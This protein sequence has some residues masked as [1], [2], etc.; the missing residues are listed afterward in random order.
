MKAFGKNKDAATDVAVE[1]IS[2]DVTPLT[3]NTD[4]RAYGKLGWVV[5][6]LG[7]G[8]FLLWAT[9][10]PLDKGVPL[11]GTVAKE[12]NR[13]AVQYLN[14]GIV[15]NIL[16]HDGDVVKAGQVLVEM[17]DVQAKSQVD[18]AH[19]MY[20]ASRAA[21]A[22]L[23]AER[24]GKPMAFPSTLLAYKN[25]PH[26]ME[27][28]ALQKELMASRQSAL[29]NELAAMDENIAGL[30][31][32]TRG[33]EES[34]LSKVEQ[35]NSLKEELSGMRDLAK[36]G[37]VARN[38]LLEVERTY[39]Q[40]SGSISEDVGN[41]GRGQRQVMELKLRRIQ[42]EQE[43]QKDVRTQ[44]SDVQKDADQMAGRMAALDYD[45]ANASVKSPVDGVVVGSTV[46]TRGGV[47]GA[48]A[49]LMDVVPTDDGLVVE[50]ILPVNLVDRVHNKLPVELIF[51][52]FNT[53]K[54]PHIPG[55]VEQVA[56]DRTVDE[57]T[58]AA[59]YKV[60]V[61]VTPEGT[62]LIAQHQLDIRPGMPVEIFVKTG[63]RTMMN[64]LLKPVFDRSKSAMSE[65]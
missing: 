53:N 29:K 17:S 52:A 50:G 18:M 30:Q 6:L 20:Y 2:H 64:Y 5:V 21:E 25:D 27:N 45:L 60:R 3:V 55:V 11:Q 1:V 40:I 28:V 41:I 32:Q 63:E 12:G 47:V 15:S 13:K 49:H 26:V 54:T 58:G 38:R 22:R 4:A 43:Y 34:R 14:G 57:R 44:L 65:E 33:L 39:A 16:V 42:R 48:G 31:D 37:Y 24:D 59:S 19:A 61:K 9:F 46:F 51:S 23:Q 35:L 7:V 8:G 62:R 36:D 10:A 56:A